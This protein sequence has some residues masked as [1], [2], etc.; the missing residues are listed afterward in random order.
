MNILRTWW[1]RCKAILQGDEG[2]GT[3]EIVLIIVILIAL[4][5]MFK[6]TIVSFVSGILSKISS[7]GSVF[8]PSSLQ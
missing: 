1:Q 4:V 3:I 8:D 5:L 7:Q 2:M 6:N